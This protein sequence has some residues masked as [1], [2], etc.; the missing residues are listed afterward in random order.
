MKEYKYSFTRYLWSTIIPD[1]FMILLLIYGIFKNI[2]NPNFNI[3][4]IVI[5]VSLY[6]INNSFIALSYPKDIIISNKNIKFHSFGRKHVYYWNDV[7]SF[8]IKEYQGGKLYLRVGN[9]NLFRGR[10]W[11]NTRMFNNGEE[12]YTKLMN[13]EKKIHP[14][15]LKFRN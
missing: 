3:Y 10:Y 11:I 13:K 1:F 12:L 6:G 2:E 8:K 9:P 5:I 15:S 4:S 14:D 7:K